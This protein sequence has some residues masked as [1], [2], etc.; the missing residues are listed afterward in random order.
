[1]IVD[2]VTREDPCMR[3]EPSDF[4]R[5]NCEK[6]TAVIVCGLSAMTLRP[7]SPLDIMTHAKNL[8]C[9]DLFLATFCRVHDA[10]AESVLCLRLLQLPPSSAS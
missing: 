9:E 6:D 3:G 1:M 2:V 5:K 4:P 7:A 8:R 10:K